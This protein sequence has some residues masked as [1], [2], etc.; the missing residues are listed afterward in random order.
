MFSQELAKLLRIFSKNQLNIKYTRK[1]LEFYQSVAERKNVSSIQETYTE[2]LN[3]LDQIE[4]RMEDLRNLVFIDQLTTN[5][6]NQVVIDWQKNKQDWQE[7][8]RFIN[9][10]TNL[11][12]I[13][14]RAF[15]K[16]EE[17]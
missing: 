14:I 4:R 8:N 9:S 16:K 13:V 6:M 1:Y 2:Y 5:Q 7:V 10:L 15:T 12:M 3:K 11:S 17:S